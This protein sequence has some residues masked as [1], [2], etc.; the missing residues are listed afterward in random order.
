MGWWSWG[1]FPCGGGFRPTFGIQSPS[2]DS[3]SF[4]VGLGYGRQS[5]ASSCC[6]LETRRSSRDWVQ[7]RWHGFLHEETED[8]RMDWA[9]ESA[10][11]WGQESMVASCRN[12]GFGGIQSGAWSQ[13]RRTSGG[14]TTAE[15]PLVTQATI[16]EPRSSGTTWF[17]P[18]GGL[19]VPATMHLVRDGLGWLM[20][21]VDS[22]RGWCLL[23]GWAD[24]PVEHGCRLGFRGLAIQDAQ[25]R[26]LGR[27]VVPLV[28][29]RVGDMLGRLG[30]LDGSRNAWDIQGG[31]GAGS[32][33]NDAAGVVVGLRDR[34]PQGKWDREAWLVVWL[35][36]VVS[37]LGRLEA[38]HPWVHHR[39]RWGQLRKCSGWSC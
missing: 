8:R 5:S 11:V 4:K 35:H 25:R 12:I 14:G 24:G 15:A 34:C 21:G 7:A 26:V 30:L 16:Y 13:C 6:H 22:I 39:P 2:W 19:E 37:N 18:C 31:L 23:V 33:A 3:R 28:G 10:G 17:G 32:Q 36:Q 29:S 1:W 20:R 9:G 38:L 27:D